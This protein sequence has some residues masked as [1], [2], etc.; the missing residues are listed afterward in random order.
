MHYFLIT[1]ISH[2]SGQN[3]LNI[4]PIVIHRVFSTETFLLYYTD[5]IDSIHR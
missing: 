1:K 2:Y 4:G 3:E 5:N